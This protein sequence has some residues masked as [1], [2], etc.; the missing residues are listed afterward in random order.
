MEEEYENNCLWCD[1]PCEKDF[2]GEECANN[3]VIER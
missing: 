1:T 3:W 2:C